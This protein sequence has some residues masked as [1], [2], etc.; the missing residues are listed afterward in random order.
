M[1]VKVWQA[2]AYITVKVNNFF[3]VSHFTR[4]HHKKHITQV[5]VYQYTKHRERK[6]SPRRNRLNSINSALNCN[7]FPV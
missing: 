3:S 4:F 1:H 5:I 6:F 2:L 7:E